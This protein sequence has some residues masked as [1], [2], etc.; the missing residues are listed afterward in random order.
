VSAGKL[1]SQR[2]GGQKLLGMIARKE[3]T[4]VVALELHRLFQEC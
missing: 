1:L 3:I 4:H 2:D